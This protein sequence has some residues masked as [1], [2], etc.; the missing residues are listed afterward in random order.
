M[1]PDSDA[2]VDNKSKCSENVY[3][4]LIWQAQLEVSGDSL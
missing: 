3:V 4:A 1:Y 2:A